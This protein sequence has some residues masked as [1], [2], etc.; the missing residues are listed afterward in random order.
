MITYS[1]YYRKQ[2]SLNKNYPVKESVSLAVRLE[3]YILEE[4]EPF[5]PEKFLEKII[6]M[7]EF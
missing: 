4:R 1:D 2:D 7:K 6:E 3:L 5:T